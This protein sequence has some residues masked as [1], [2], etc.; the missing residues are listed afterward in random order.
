M[1]EHQM[2]E[3]LGRI[4]TGMEHNRSKEALQ[5]IARN[6]SREHGVPNAIDYLSEAIENAAGTIADAIHD[7]AKAIRQGQP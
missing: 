2:N 5:D 7:L 3:L 4:A 1:N 6:L